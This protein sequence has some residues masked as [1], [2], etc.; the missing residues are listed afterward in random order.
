MN[1][2]QTRPRKLNYTFVKPGERNEEPVDLNKVVA[3]FTQ[4][5]TFPK[6]NGRYLI[7]QYKSN[8]IDEFISIKDYELSKQQI[9][10]FI[11]TSKDNTYKCYSTTSLKEINPPNLHDIYVSKS[12][13]MGILKDSSYTGFAKF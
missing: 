2:G 13:T 4:V 12:G 6:H 9:K 10:D 5:C 11:D 8:V 7:R 1:H 3:T